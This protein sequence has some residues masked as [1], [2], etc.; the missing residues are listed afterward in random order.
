MLNASNTQR[1]GLHTLVLVILTALA[2]SGVLL[3]LWLSLNLALENGKSIGM[4]L[5]IYLGF[6]TVLTN[7]FVAL[8]LSFQLALTFKLT[9]KETPIS[10]FFTH[11]QTMACAATS[12]VLVGLGYHFLLRHIWNPQ[13]LQWLADVQLHYVMP[14]LFC[15]YWLFALPKSVLGWWSPLLACIYPVGYFA[16]ALIRGSILG[17]YPY[18]FIDVTTIG[19]GLT[20]RNAFGLLIVFILVGFVLLG[21]GKANSHF[22]VR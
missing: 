15:L 12:I 9:T 7:I 4:G 1:S 2:W 3:Q 16:Y 17:A 19:Y 8:I 6:F 11:P 20:L 5:I 14:V 10:R 22:K 21:L 13:G 18:P